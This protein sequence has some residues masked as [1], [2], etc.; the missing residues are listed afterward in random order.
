MRMPGV[1]AAVGA[2]IT[3]NLVIKE[4]NHG[5]DGANGGGD[6]AQSGCDYRWACRII[7]EPSREDG[8]YL[9]VATAA[10]A[11]K[12]R[13]FDTPRVKFGRRFYRTWYRWAFKTRLFYR[14]GY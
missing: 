11:L 12:A 4:Q 1:V 10:F 5:G 9:T 3:A 2:V 14:L 6:D 7:S 13:V 8:V